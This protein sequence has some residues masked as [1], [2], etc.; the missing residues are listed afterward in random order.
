MPHLLDGASIVIIRI[1]IFFLNPSFSSLIH[2]KLEPLH[3][4]EIL[5][6]RKVLVPW[7]CTERKTENTSVLDAVIKLVCQDVSVLVNHLH[8]KCAVELGLAINIV[9]NYEF[10]TNAASQTCGVEFHS[11]INL[12]VV[13]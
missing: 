8:W 11:S 12:S 1:G 13:D 10:K 6:V 4:C 3:E 2:L 5:T 7:V 9:I